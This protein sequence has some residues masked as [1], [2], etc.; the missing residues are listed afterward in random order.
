MIYLH[1]SKGNQL[2]KAIADKEGRGSHPS[3]GHS[4]GG[5]VLRQYLQPELET[6]HYCVK[7]Q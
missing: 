2:E 7:G 3:K 4:V 5:E 6:K 1:C